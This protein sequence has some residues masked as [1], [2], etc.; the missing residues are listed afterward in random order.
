MQN[1]ATMEEILDEVKCI[2]KKLKRLKWVGM[3]SENQ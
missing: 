1:V 3:E 2:G